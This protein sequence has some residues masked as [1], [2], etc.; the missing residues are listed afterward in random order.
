[1]LIFVEEILSPD[2]SLDHSNRCQ[3][4]EFDSFREY[5]S[6]FVDFQELFDCQGDW[7]CTLW[8]ASVAVLVLSLSRRTAFLFNWIESEFFLS[9][10][11]Q[12]I[13]RREWTD[14]TSSVARATLIESPCRSNGMRKTKKIISEKI[15]LSKNRWRTTDEIEEI[16]DDWMSHR[17]I[18][19]E[20]KKEREGEGE[21]KK[22]ERDTNAL[23][24]L[25]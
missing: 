3:Y 19:T 18:S 5:V 24:L 14:R 8:S 15:F 20:K 17:H 21:E 7:S 6:L 13:G 25:E 22:R 2:Y 16:F 12:L 1:M 23:V 9:R 10:T 11:S 4:E